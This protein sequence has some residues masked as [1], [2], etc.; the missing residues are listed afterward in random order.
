MLASWVKIVVEGGSREVEEQEP[1]SVL[2]ISST[3]QF[4]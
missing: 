2:F 4:S 1:N 3:L